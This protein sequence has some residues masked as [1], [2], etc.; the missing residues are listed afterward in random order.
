MAKENEKLKTDFRNH[1]KF[2][3]SSVMNSTSSVASNKN[4]DLKKSES[5]TE[6]LN[7]IKPRSSLGKS[8]TTIKTYIGD[9]T[10]SKSK[11]DYGDRSDY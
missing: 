7:E 10:T 9:Y 2:L 6:S 1:R 8:P 11:K 3:H 4:L 5:L